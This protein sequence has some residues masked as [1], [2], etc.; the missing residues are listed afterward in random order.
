MRSIQIH[1]FSCNLHSHTLAVVG[2]I[3]PSIP[4]TV[5][6]WEKEASSDQHELRIIFQKCD[7]KHFGA[8][9]AALHS[10]K[11]IIVTISFYRS[12]LLASVTTGEY[13]L[14]SGGGNNMRETKQVALLSLF[15]EQF[16]GESAQQLLFAAINLVQGRFG[17]WG[18][19]VLKSQEQKLRTCKEHLPLKGED[20]W[21]ET[22]V[23]LQKAPWNKD[24]PLRH[25]LGFKCNFRV[26]CSS[27]CATFRTCTEN[28][29]GEYN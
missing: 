21:D 2:L 10:R 22:A 6:L 9:E 23:G 7:L 15:E 27:L 25:H 5:D 19:Q 12:C 26:A 17:C 13:H 29:I 11:R 20:V 1:L 3:R 24:S 18:Q 16:R 14:F 4:L 8:T 28:Q